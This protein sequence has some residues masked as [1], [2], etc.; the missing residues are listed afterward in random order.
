MDN[1]DV[2]ILLV[3]DNS[4]DAEM[5]IRAL[6]KMN[7]AN[8]LVRVEDGGEALDFLF[9]RGAYSSREITNRPRLILLDIKMPRIDGI[10]VLRQIKSDEATKM[11]PVV[12]M[13]SSKEDQDVVTSYQLGANGY[14]V[15]PV[16]FEGFARAVSSLGFYWLLTNQPPSN[17]Q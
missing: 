15:K 10:E 12:V 2:E 11:I 5:T 7:L 1:N 9:G 6:K 13:T 3:E 8:S 17:G 16:D 14:V 4:Y